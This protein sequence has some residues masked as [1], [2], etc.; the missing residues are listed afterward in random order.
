MH[1]V[2]VF[3]HA[4]ASRLGADRRHERQPRAVPSAP[5]VARRG[6]AE[7]G[8]GVIVACWARTLHGCRGRAY[9]RVRLIRQEVRAMCKTRNQVHS[10]HI[11][12][13]DTAAAIA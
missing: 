6:G 2:R 9:R 1:W 11:K 8:I 13:A 5:W 10:T 7:D 12:S 4:D 3:R